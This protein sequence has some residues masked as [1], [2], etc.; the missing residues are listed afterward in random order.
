[1]AP[2]KAHS[3]ISTQPWGEVGLP[4]YPL[5]HAQL[6]EPGVFVH[7][8]LAVQLLRDGVAHSLMST[9][10]AEPLM[11]VPLYPGLHKHLSFEQKVLALHWDSGS[12]LVQ[13]HVSPSSV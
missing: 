12:P 1:M 10:P 13:S 2:F 8:V 7:T 9:Q 11:G 4:A 6:N 3:L 5:A